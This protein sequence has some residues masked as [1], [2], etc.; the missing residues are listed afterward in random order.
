[1][2]QHAATPKG[3]STQDNIE[4]DEVA[5]WTV[6]L[7]ELHAAIAECCGRPAGSWLSMQGIACPMGCNR[8]W[9][10]INAM[11]ML[12]GMTCGPTYW[13]NWLIRGLSWCSMKRGF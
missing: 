2:V 7:N 13:R 4:L 3:G 11:P 10:R 6:G 8:Y 1:V 5:D 9:P 12:C